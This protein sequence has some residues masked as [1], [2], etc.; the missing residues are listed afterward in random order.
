MF[1]SKRSTSLLVDIKSIILSTL[2]LPYLIQND[3]LECLKQNYSA[4]KAR[5][6]SFYYYLEGIAKILNIVKKHTKETNCLK[7]FNTFIDGQFFDNLLD[8]SN[9]CE[10]EFVEGYSTISD[11]FDELTQVVQQIEPKNSKGEDVNEVNC[12]KSA[13]KASDYEDDIAKLYEMKLNE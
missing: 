7:L 12:E 3:C 1:C 11:E 4:S 10:R 6:N 2:Q 9:S 5:K 13:E 8:D